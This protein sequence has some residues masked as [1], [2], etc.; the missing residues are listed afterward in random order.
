MSRPRR[1]S[2]RWHSNTNCTT[3]R[4]SAPL[5]SRKATARLTQLQAVAGS[6]TTQLQTAAARIEQLQATITKSLSST[7]DADIAKTSIAYSNE[8]A[9]Y[10]AALRAG[11]SIVQESLLNFLR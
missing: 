5:S 2:A 8:Q 4:S 9:A 3:R 11:A 10:E 1:R 6:V 7:V